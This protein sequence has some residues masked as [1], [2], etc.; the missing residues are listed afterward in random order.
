MC[1]TVSSHAGAE[2]TECVANPSTI[3]GERREGETEEVL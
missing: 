2:R 3:L 1:H